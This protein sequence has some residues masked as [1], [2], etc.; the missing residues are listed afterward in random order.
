M[1]IEVVATAIALAIKDSGKFRAEEQKTALRYIAAE[2]APE[3][4]VEN[5]GRIG[6]VSAVRQ[7]LE[8]SGIIKGS[9]SDSALCR[10]IKA[11]QEKLAII[12]ASK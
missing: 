1:N 11:A 9:E 3:E 2:S 10:A 5:I 12:T 6:N 8:K 7:E 4:L